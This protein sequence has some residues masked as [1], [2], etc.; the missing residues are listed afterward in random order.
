MKGGLAVIDGDGNDS[1]PLKELRDLEKEILQAPVELAKV[2]K[3]LGQR[4]LRL[5]PFHRKRLEVARLRLLDGQVE[6][7][8]QVGQ[9]RLQVKPARLSLVPSRWD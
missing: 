5:L 2:E 6:L 9:L 1:L 3:A 4:R 8:D 7:T